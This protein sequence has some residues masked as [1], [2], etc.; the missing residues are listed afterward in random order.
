M[1]S[2]SKKKN[3][4]KTSIFVLSI[5]EYFQGS[6]KGE[7]SLSSA[8]QRTT[9][10]SKAFLQN[11]TQNKNTLEEPKPSNFIKIIQTRSG[12][13]LETN[14]SFAFHYLTKSIFLPVFEMEIS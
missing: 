6:R 11:P 14:P 13:L 1:V 3:K 10:A 7:T 4:N 8:S 12:K 9:L 5:D 2:S